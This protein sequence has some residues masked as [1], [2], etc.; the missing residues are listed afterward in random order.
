MTQRPGPCFLLTE[1]EFYGDF[2]YLIL[3][4][5]IDDRVSSLRPTAYLDGS[6]T[7][8]GSLHWGPGI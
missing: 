7:G 6:L 8:V 5:S 2:T 4:N 1:L 3:G